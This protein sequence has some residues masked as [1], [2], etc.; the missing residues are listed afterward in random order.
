MRAPAHTLRHTHKHTR[1][2]AVNAGIAG[3]FIHEDACISQSLHY[4]MLMRSYI[5]LSTERQQLIFFYQWNVNGT[6]HE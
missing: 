3:A 6:L 5:L 4:V 1:P 2:R